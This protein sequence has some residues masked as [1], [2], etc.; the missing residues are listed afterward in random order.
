[1][2]KD[3]IIVEP[4]GFLN[5]HGEAKWSEKHEKVWVGEGN[6]LHKHVTIDTVSVL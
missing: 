5:V 6:N 1:M 4:K 3:T 2:R